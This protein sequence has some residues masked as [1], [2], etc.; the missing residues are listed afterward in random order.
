MSHLFGRVRV[1]EH[2]FAP[3]RVSAINSHPL[4]EENGESLTG[5]ASD[6]TEKESV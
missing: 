1:S 4:L 6:L 5:E 2:G 3:V